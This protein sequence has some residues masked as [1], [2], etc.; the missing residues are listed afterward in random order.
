MFIV[1]A[2]DIPNNKRRT[3]VMKLLQGYGEHVQESVF[4]CD[5]DAGTYRKLRKRLNALIN[6][7]Q[8]NLRLYHLCQGDVARIEPVGVARAVQLTKVFKVV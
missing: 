2:Y 5:L 6:V 7:E 3:R 4:E 1:I 8:D